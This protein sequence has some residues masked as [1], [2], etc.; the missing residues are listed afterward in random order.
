MTAMRKA[1]SIDEGHFLHVTVDNFSLTFLVDIGSYVTIIPKDLAKQLSKEMYKKV[2]EKSRRCHNHNP[3]PFP[4]T[5]RKRKQR[6]KPNK[7]NA[8]KCTKSKCLSSPSEVIVVLK[9]LKNTRTK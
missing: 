3:Q 8:N 2:R 1:W 7:H 5:K 6:R 4:D 9:G